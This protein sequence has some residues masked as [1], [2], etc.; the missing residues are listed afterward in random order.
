VTTVS[1][2][3]LRAI[4]LPSSPSKSGPASCPAI[5]LG[6]PRASR[7]PLA[8]SVIVGVHMLCGSPGAV[9][10]QVAL[11]ARGVHWP[12]AA[13]PASSHLDV[14]SSLADRRS[15]LSVEQDSQ[16]RP[17]GSPRALSPSGRRAWRVERQC[18]FR[19]RVAPARSPERCAGQKPLGRRKEQPPAVPVH[20]FRPRRRGGRARLAADRRAASREDRL[21]AISARWRPN[22]SSRHSA[23]L[24]E[25]G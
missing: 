20:S 22:A 5:G 3:E 25:R 7:R 16:P 17:A 23:S 13:E 11:D 18:T 4:E 10:E 24:E 12:G 1:S 8:K 15:C 2:S 19:T 21:S 9:D 6:G 14:E